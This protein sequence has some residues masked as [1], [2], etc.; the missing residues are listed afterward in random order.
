MSRFNCSCGALA[1]EKRCACRQAFRVSLL[2]CASSLAALLLAGCVARP[3]APVPQTITVHQVEYVP[4]VWPAALQSCPPDP[5]PVV[6][7]HIAA[8]DPHGGSKAATYLAKDDAYKAAVL[9]AL[10]DCRA[11]LAAAMAAN[12]GAN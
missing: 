12:R 9:G 2:F 5:T 4:W 10:D 11:T 1:G 8:D 3:A 6:R 7:P